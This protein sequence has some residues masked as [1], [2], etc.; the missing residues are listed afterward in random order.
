MTAPTLSH[1]APGTRPATSLS[2]AEPNRI[3]RQA[4]ALSMLGFAALFVGAQLLHPDPFAGMEP[5]DGA[6]YLAAFHDRPLLHMAHLFEFFAGA[7]LIVLAAHFHG[8]TRRH[9]PNWALL[10]LVMAAAGAV[11]LIGN[12]AAIC[13][14]ASAFDTLPEAQLATLVPALDMLI[15]RQGNMAILNLLPLLPLGFV[16]F[17]ILLW[18][19]RALPRWQ[20]GFV[21][22]GSLLLVNPGVQA[23]NTLG[24]L[25]LAIGIVPIGLSLMRG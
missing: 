2:P 4:V 14:S 25:M 1:Q 9:H 18:Q 24:A 8:L 5:M 7:L 15:T 23:M 16:L 20:A 13:L 22:L 21:T 10:A 19:A 17:G 6:A 11:M 12:K 3:E